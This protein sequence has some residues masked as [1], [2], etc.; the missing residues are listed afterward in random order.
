MSSFA[1]GRSDIRAE[2][3]ALSDEAD[4]QIEY[5]ELEGEV[6]RAWAF[7]HLLHSPGASS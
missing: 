7:L 4:L 5:L 6:T 1:S 2:L 3:E